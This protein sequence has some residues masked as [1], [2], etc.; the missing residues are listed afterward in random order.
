[1]YTPIKFFLSSSAAQKKWSTCQYTEILCVRKSR[2]EI[3]KKDIL[4][5]SIRQQK[6]HAHIQVFRKKEKRVDLSFERES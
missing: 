5:I 4:N 6:T 2:R 3:C 1:M